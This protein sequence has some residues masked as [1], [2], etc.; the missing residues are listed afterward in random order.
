MRHVRF[1][2]IG[3]A[4]AALPMSAVAQQQQPQQQ[5]PGWQASNKAMGEALKAKD[6]K[7]ALA[8]AAA[9]LAGYRA[10]GAPD[11]KLLLNLAVNYA[12]VAMQA[13]DVSGAV[14]ALGSVDE[15]LAKLGPAGV[16]GRAYILR[17]ISALHLAGGNQAAQQRTLATLVDA[18]R[19]GLGPD[20][21]QTA[22]ALVELANAS[23]RAGGYAAAK[24][25]M[26]AAEAIAVKLPADD[27]S[28]AAIELT[29]AN[30]EAQAG[31]DAEAVRRLTAITGRI[32]PTDDRSRAVWVAA[33]VQLAQL[34]ARASRMADVDKVVGALIANTPVNPEAA[35]IVLA[36]PD[37]AKAKQPLDR[38]I[39]HA[40]TA[41]FDVGADG[42]LRNIRVKLETGSPAYAPLAEQAIAQSRYMPVITDG[43]PQ[44]TVNQTVSF[45]LPEQSQPPAGS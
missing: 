6:L 22:L 33:S 3:L 32:Q 40:A 42:K 27:P 38:N 10:A 1:L 5:A 19:N 17:A 45:V 29:A 25:H 31:N 16:P 14:A 21:P 24:P 11:Q 26:A 23:A 43:K 4:L 8:H 7:G 13:R 30:I 28:R 36:E 39:R 35:P 41:T 2:G 37:P 34:H 15:D 20:H 12:D 18:A 44:P 9:A